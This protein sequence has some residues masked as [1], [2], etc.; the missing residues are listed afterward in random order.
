M[1]GSEGRITGGSRAQAQLASSLPCGRVLILHYYPESIATGS[2]H[3]AHQL[4]HR[5]CEDAEHQVAPT[6]SSRPQRAR[7]A[8]GS[9][10][11]GGLRYNAP[12]AGG[13]RNK[14]HPPLYPATCTN[15]Q[16]PDHRSGP[17]RAPLTT[18][19]APDRPIPPGPGPS[20]KNGPGHDVNAMEHRA[21]L[22]FAHRRIPKIIP[23]PAV[24][25]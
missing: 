23:C 21:V 8:H 3:Q 15:Q 7:A 1:S 6:R 4:F 13:T 5:Q 11:S 25:G 12:R 14:P 24:T 2:K 17:R 16:P 19:P 10:H 18:T 22:S 9:A 20:K